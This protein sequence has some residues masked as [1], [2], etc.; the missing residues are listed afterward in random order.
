MKTNILCVL[1]AC[2]LSFGALSKE[3]KI[4][5][6]FMG[7]WEKAEKLSTSENTLWIQEW[8][9]NSEKFCERRFER[10]KLYN[11][12]GRFKKKP[13]SEYMTSCQA[14]IEKQYRRGA[15]NAFLPSKIGLYTKER[16][17]TSEESKWQK[18]G[19][20]ELTAG[21]ASL[22]GFAV[23]LPSRTIES[24]NI[25]PEQL[26]AQFEALRTGT[27]SGTVPPFINSSDPA[28]RGKLNIQEGT[29]GMRYI[30]AQSCSRYEWSVWS[31]AKKH[32]EHSKAK[33]FNQTLPIYPGEKVYLFTSHKAPLSEGTQLGIEIGKAL[34]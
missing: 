22:S 4:L 27:T 12:L 10:R 6:D 25:T 13:K 8:G 19:V 26:S 23:L 16:T 1:V 9:V 31:G 28:T 33:L 17:S 18:G 34:P 3:S 32:F 20:C 29:I 30:M 24:I 5:L 21:E 7:G 11:K 15:L 14:S 2:L